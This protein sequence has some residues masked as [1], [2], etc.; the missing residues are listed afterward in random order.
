MFPVH[1]AND[2]IEEYESENRECSSYLIDERVS[3]D[4]YGS[5]T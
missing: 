2:P 3:A 5:K 4:A 1:Y